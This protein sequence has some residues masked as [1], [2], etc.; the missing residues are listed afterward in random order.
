MGGTKK[1]AIKLATLS[2]LTSIPHFEWQASGP[3]TEDE[4]RHVLRFCGLNLTKCAKP[5]INEHSAI[6]MLRD[7]AKKLKDTSAEELVVN[8]HNQKITRDQAR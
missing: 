8:M 4:K 1:T 7:W 2:F 6:R 5:D 3:A